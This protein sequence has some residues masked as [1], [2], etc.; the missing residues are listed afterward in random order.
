MDEGR[1]VSRHSELAAELLF[2]VM[3]P[4]VE[5]GVGCVLIELH[6]DWGGLLGQEQHCG[7]EYDY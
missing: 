6:D 1:A 7:C 2:G 4:D 3:T 5:A